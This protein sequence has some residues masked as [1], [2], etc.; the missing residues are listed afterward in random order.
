MAQPTDGSRQSTIGARYGSVSL[1]FGTVSAIN[2]AIPSLAGDA[3]ADMFM[4]A[5]AA[6]AVCAALAL[7]LRRDPKRVAPKVTTPARMPDS[8]PRPVGRAQPVTPRV[9]G[10]SRGRPAVQ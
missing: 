3:G 1:V 7:M 9:R 8:A 6:T 4:A 5:A 2:L 10:G